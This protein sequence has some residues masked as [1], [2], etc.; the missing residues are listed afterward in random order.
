[1]ITTTSITE[2]VRDESNRYSARARWTG[3]G[4][5]L[6]FSVLLL[7]SML[8]LTGCGSRNSVERHVERGRIYQKGQQLTGAA[9][10]FR[11][12]LEIDPDNIDAR[13][14]LGSVLAEKNEHDEAEQ[15]FKRVLEL[16]PGHRL[17]Y[18]GLAETY[19]ARKDYESLSQL[20]DTMGRFKGLS[21]NFQGIVA[22]TNDD[23]DTAVRLFR[24]AVEEEPQPQ[25]MAI[26][27][28]PTS[29]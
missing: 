1:M 5:W 26:S 22:R 19:V 28:T 23:L 24:A 15:H 10:E 6:T 25:T 3:V 9:D 27:A 20:A 7:A 17:S 4:M 29:R 16:E 2:R 11:K 21:H 8:L 12:A 14:Y 13:Y 18:V